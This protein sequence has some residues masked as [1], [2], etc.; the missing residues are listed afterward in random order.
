MTV[1]VKYLGM[2]DYV[3]SK[4][5]AI[6]FAIFFLATTVVHIY[7]LVRGK[8]WFFIPF[9]IGCIFE[10]VGYLARAKSSTQYPDYSTGPEIIQ[11]LLILVAP[12]LLAASIYMEF[13]RVMIMA[14]GEKYSII[15]RTWLTKIFVCG[16]V[17]SFFAQFCGAAMLAKSST[18]SKGLTIMKIGVLIQILFF[19]LF[20]VTII[21]FH[22]R[23]V[24]NGSS[25]YHVVPWK[26]H[27]FAMYATGLLI[28]VRSIFRFAEFVDSNGPLTEYEWVAYVF[29]AVLILAASIIMNVI[30]PA[31]IK[32]WVERAYQMS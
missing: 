19:A 11:Y 30:H 23:L 5:A 4:G 25:S 14:D 6:A 9:I 31:D 2:Y 15:R 29:D 32:T 12:A 27:V 26:K 24:K 13:G 7:Q 28:F 21:L 10:I 8:T 22:K 18:A 3:P 1:T 17:L 16:D 20:I